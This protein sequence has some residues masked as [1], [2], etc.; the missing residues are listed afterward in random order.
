LSEVEVVGV[1]VVVL[2]GKYAKWGGNL[3]RKEKYLQETLQMWGK[4]R[5]RKSLKPLISR[6]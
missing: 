6:L 1:F 5:N 2:V 4:L 3:W